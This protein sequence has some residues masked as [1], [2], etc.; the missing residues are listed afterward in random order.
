MLLLVVL[1]RKRRRRSGLELKKRRWRLRQRRNRLLL[2]MMMVVTHL[3]HRRRRRRRRVITMLLMVVLL[4]V[5]RRRR[6]T[7]MLFVVRNRN[8]SS[9]SS[10]VRRRRGGGERREPSPAVPLLGRRP[11]YRELRAAENV[12]RILRRVGHDCVDGVRRRKGHEADAPV[13]QSSDGGGGGRCVFVGGACRPTAA[14]SGA[15]SGRQ[16]SSGRGAPALASSFFGHIRV[17]DLSEAG[18]VVPEGLLVDRGRHARDEDA[19]GAREPRQR[20]SRPQSATA[21]AVRPVAAA[22]VIQLLPSGSGGVPSPVR[23]VSRGR[24]R[25]GGP[26]PVMLLLIIKIIMTRSG[27]CLHGGGD[28]G[29]GQRCF[30]L[31]P[32]PVDAVRGIARCGGGCGGV[33]EGDEAEAAGAA[34]G[35]TAHDDGVGEGSFDIL[36]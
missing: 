17:R 32:P 5:L 25:R 16:S 33:D 19:G 4:P 15:S 12:R 14:S 7:V 23:V 11:V 36:F 6:R 20:R 26:S 27:C 21:V 2:M 24:R 29:S 3:L 10:A 9:G 22:G 30:R 1:R 18:P 35:A 31:A 28:R 13:G 8:S 34:R